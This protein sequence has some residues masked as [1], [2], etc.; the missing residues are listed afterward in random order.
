[1][2]QY[3]GMQIILQ[4]IIILFSIIIHEISHGYAALALGDKTAK[5]AGRLTLNPIKHIDPFGTIILPI[6]MSII[7][8]GSYVFGWAK[9][10]PYNPYNLSNQKW[11]DAIVALAGPASNFVIA[12]VF[13]ILLHVG[14]SQGLVNVAFME[15]ATYVILINVILGSFNL[16]PIPPLDGSKIF[17]SFLPYKYIHIRHLFE[18]YGFALLVFFILFLWNP[19]M[20]IVISIARFV[21]ILV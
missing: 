18:R 21:G 9:P 16:I 5:M 14:L 20:I 3:F 7:T 1:M 2:L 6:A 13:S 8:H 17:F 12:I 10:V 15:M 4:I 19:F 11:G